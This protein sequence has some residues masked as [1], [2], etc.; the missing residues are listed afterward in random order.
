VDDGLLQDMC[1]HQ[2]GMGEAGG[3]FN[4]GVLAVQPGPSSHSYFDSDSVEPMTFS[5]V[6]ENFSACTSIRF[7]ILCLSDLK[8]FPTTWVS[9]FLFSLV[10]CCLV[11]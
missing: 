10:R 3:V 1:L 8:N 7:F 11:E 5:D 2:F 9:R 6:S 4:V